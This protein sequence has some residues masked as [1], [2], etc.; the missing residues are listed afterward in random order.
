M[1]SDVHHG[2][3]EECGSRE[4]RWKPATKTWMQGEWQRQWKRK[5]GYERDWWVS[6]QNGNVG[7]LVQRAEKKS[8]SK[9][10]K[11]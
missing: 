8:V 4:T 10:T 3:R 9:S 7:L 2:D 1:T 6:V 11:T 5:S